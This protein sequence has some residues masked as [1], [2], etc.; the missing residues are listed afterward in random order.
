MESHRIFGIETPGEFETCA[1][2]TFQDQ[3]KQVPVYR[4][5]CDLLGRNPTNVLRLEDIAFLPI[6][7]FKTHKVFRTWNGTD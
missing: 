1:L 4:E 3:Y 5:F 6:E 2:E 7:F